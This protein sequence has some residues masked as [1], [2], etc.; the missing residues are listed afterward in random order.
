MKSFTIRGIENELYNEI[1]KLSD[2][3]SMSVNKFILALLKEDTGLKK[4][5]KYTRVYDDID[6]LFGK[7]KAKEHR[8][9]TKKI[10]SERVID[11]ELWK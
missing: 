11:K 2:D 6:S 4:D 7:W 3:K 8:L 9:I 10:S 5:K 1:K